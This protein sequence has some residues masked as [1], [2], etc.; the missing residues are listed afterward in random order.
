MKNVTRHHGKLEIIQRL[1]RSLNGNPRYLL[2]VDGWTCRTAPDSGLAY[3]ITN[4][5]GKI[6][7][8][9]IGTYRGNATI[10]DVSLAR[11]EN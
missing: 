1:P 7:T 3:A 4:F 10:S 9:T 11:A 6:V 2:R 8:A 5:D